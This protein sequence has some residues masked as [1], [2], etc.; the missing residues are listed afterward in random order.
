MREESSV[1]PTIC[2][3]EARTRTRV[4]VGG[5]RRGS[6]WA[7]YA[8]A[9]NPGWC[10]RRASR[11]EHRGGVGRVGRPTEAQLR[12]TA[13]LRYRTYRT[14]GDRRARD[15]HATRSVRCRLLSEGRRHGQAD[16]DRLDACTAAARLPEAQLPAGPIYP[17]RPQLLSATRTSPTLGAARRREPGEARD[18]DRVRRARV[19]SSRRRVR[20]RIWPN[21]RPSATGRTSSRLFA[22]GCHGPCG[23]SP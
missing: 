4:G 17:R 23:G 9:R 2:L 3:H 12:G 20:L 16:P 5:R 21:A 8:C 22:G 15:L 1:T 7:R 18:A 11:N 13:D 14:A 6:S 19:R 10:R